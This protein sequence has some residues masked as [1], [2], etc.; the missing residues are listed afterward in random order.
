MNE[1][2][3]LSLSPAA[4]IAA[5][6]VTIVLF[7]RVDPLAARLLVPHLVSVMF[8]TALNIA[9]ARPNR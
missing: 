8:A 2:V 3:A 4:L 9:I 7:A 6:V 5:I 1:H